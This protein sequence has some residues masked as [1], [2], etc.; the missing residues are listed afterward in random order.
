MQLD[1]YSNSYK[2]DI[3]LLKQKNITWNQR[4]C[5][6]LRSG[7]K[8]ILLF[9][10]DMSEKMIRLLNTTNKKVIFVFQW[11]EL[12]KFMHKQSNAKYLTYVNKVIL[13]LLAKQD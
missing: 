12:V 5:V 11:Q 2:E 6:L 4:N 10:I 9:Y 1:A 7:E 13:P 3:A 8:Q